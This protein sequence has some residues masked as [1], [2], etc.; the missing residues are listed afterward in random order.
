MERLPG[1]TKN[2]LFTRSWT[3]RVWLVHPWADRGG[4]TPSGR[5]SG[6]ED[7]ITWSYTRQQKTTEKKSG[8]SSECT[9]LWQILQRKD[10][11]SQSLSSKDIAKFFIEK[12][13]ILST[14]IAAFVLALCSTRVTRPML[15]LC[16]N[17]ALLT[18]VK[19]WV[20]EGGKATLVGALDADIL[21]EEL[22]KRTTAGAET[23]LVKVKAHRGDLQMK[24]PTSKQTRLF[25]AKMF[26]RNGTT[27]QIEQES[28]R[29]WQ[30]K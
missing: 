16:D 26:P 25:Q 23:F 6:R 27:G 3:A 9:P 13:G 8:K 10:T 19:K 12:D 18:A 7:I 20:N 4:S 22:R 17:Q 21:L 28:P 15:Y 14:I 30:Q 11:G 24:K 1:N 2:R 5:L 29:K